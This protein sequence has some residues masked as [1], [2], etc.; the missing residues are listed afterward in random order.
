MRKPTILFVLLLLQ[1][2]AVWAQQADL[3]LP[4][5]AHYDRVQLRHA[6]NDL[7][8][9]Y[10]LRF[11]YSSDHIPL[12]QRVSVHRERA[13]LKAVL[14]D[15][16]AETQVVY[17]TIG[18]QIVLKHDPGK[19]IRNPWKPEGGKREYREPEIQL[20]PM[21]SREIGPIRMETETPPKL[22]PVVL[23]PPDKTVFSRWQTWAFFDSLNM[24]LPDD[25]RMYQLSIFP[26]FGTNGWESG[27]LSNLHSV[28]LLAGYSAGV[29]GSEW[30][31]LMNTTEGDVKGIQVAGFANVAE[32][33]LYGR[34]VAG[35]LNLSLRRARGLQVAGFLNAAGEISGNQIALAGNLSFVEMRG[36][37]IAALF[38][39]SAGAAGTQ[40][41]LINIADTVT[42]VSIGLL[43]LVRRGYNRFELAGSESLWT[44]VAFKPGTRRFYNIFYA[45]FR[46]EETPIWG[47]GYGA[48]TAIGLSRRLDL[49]LEGLS[50]HL[51][52]GGSIEGRL[53]L[54]NQ[55]R[56]TLDCRIGRRFSIFGGGTLNLM[57]SRVVDPETGDR[58]Y[59]L[60]PYNWYR[61]TTAGGTDYQAW[62]GVLGGIRF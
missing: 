47:L 17:A 44:S 60:A 26:P 45:G 6:L 14:D 55:L 15:L 22:E 7:E 13:P 61:R 62:A 4:V 42:N 41:G 8:R 12:S 54:L 51:S 16:F 59:D 27:K 20:L 11:S 31:L 32:E 25:K 57:V 36:R 52:K 18:R 49:N 38:N 43:N 3:S 40:F 56:L 33:S 24:G 34:Q 35:V 58:S 53:N 46:W 23:P 30:S 19:P 28:N 10:D 29:E 21:G 2:L 48:G 50:I 39:Y 5:S 1:T 37:Q 9:R